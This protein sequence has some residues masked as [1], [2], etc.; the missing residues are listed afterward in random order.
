M[1][2]S[3]IAAL[4]EARASQRRARALE[5]ARE[6]LGV[7]TKQGLDAAIVGSLARDEFH[8]HSDIDILILDHLSPAMRLAT[9]RQVAQRMSGREIPVD[10]IFAD[11]VHPVTLVELKQD[12]VR[13]SDLFAT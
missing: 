2:G 11:D 12:A 9:E 13:S 6:L 4:L 5:A 8:A 1:T 10:L 7:F 3:R